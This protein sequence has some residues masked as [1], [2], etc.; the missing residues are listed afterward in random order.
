MNLM[1]FTNKISSDSKVAA[2][3]HAD[4]FS[5]EVT[6]YNIINGMF[7]DE[8]IEAI[9]MSP[10][11]HAPEFKVTVNSESVASYAG[12]SLN[13]RVV[14]GAFKPLYEISA[15]SEKNTVSFKLKEK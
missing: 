10:S 8:D 4:F 15:S 3:R 5:H 9:S 13:G 2:M 14:P 1:E 12:E 11:I 7:K 6:A